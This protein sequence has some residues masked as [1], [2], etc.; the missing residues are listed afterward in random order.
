M[1]SSSSSSK[2]QP[3]KSPNPVSSVEG[4]PLSVA[5]KIAIRPTLYT[6]EEVSEEEVRAEELNWDDSYDKKDDEE[7]GLD[8]A[9][10]FPHPN[11]ENNDTAQKPPLVD[12]NVPLERTSLQEEHSSA[13]VAE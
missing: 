12:T 6:I 11:A 9:A 7:N 8:E 5:R 1:E 10:L 3:E 2:R 13:S 4:C